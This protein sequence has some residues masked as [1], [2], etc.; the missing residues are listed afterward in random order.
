MQPAD[1]NHAPTDEPSEGALV[2]DVAGS[3]PAVLLLH[4][5]PGS[6]AQ[7][8][9]VIP[10]LKDRYTV[11]SPD[12]LGYGRTGGKAGGFT[13]NAQAVVGLLDRLELD[14]VIVVGHS[15]GGGVALALAGVAPERLSGLVLVSSVGPGE[16]ITVVDRLLAIR[17][18]GTVAMTI[19]LAAAKRVLEIPTVRSIGQNQPTVNA[20]IA[21]AAPDDR[22]S[23]R[24]STPSIA[25]RQGGVARA[26]AVEQ[27]AFI[28]ELEGLSADAAAVNAPTAV[29]TGGADRV[30]PPETS[31]RLAKEIKGAKLVLVP[32][33]GHL[34]PFDH[35][36]DVVMA[37]DNVA[38][39][40]GLVRPDQDR[41]EAPG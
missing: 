36:S 11:V 30:V 20:A 15:Y 29:L 24:L 26:F 5:Q 3:G 4:G 6:A 23:Q 40:A 13:A 16:P 9:H 31:H 22:R 38:S 34:L 1:A 35:P 17:P 37:I 18:L 8:A 41:E 39:A 21:I 27:R 19:G 2:A 7:W 25:W 28:D 32:G 14:R 33:A 10:P 12:R